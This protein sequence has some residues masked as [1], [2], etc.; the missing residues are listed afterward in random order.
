[1]VLETKGQKKPFDA[2][3]AFDFTDGTVG[4]GSASGTDEYSL[5][6]IAKTNLGSASCAA[7]YNVSLTVSDPT[8]ASSCST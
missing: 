2:G 1:L 4:T 6:I 3:F 5:D 7:K 8:R